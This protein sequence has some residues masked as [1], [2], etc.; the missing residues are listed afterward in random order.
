MTD[1]FDPFEA[2]GLRLRNRIALSPLTRTR[3][4]MAGKVGALQAEYYAQRASA[5]LLI[6]EAT[7]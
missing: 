3:A 4:D 6:T 7:A 1:L 2:G 5:G